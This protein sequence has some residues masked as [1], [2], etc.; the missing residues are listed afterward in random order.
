MSQGQRGMQ[1]YGSSMGYQP[2]GMNRGGFQP[3]NQNPTFQNAM[4]YAGQRMGQMPGFSQGQPGQYGMAGSS[5]NFRPPDGRGFTEPPPWNQN[6]GG[7]MVPSGGGSDFRYT[8]NDADLAGLQ[9]GSSSQV[10]SAWQ[11]S[12]SSSGGSMD[13]GRVG[14]NMAPGGYQNSWGGTGGM[15]GPMEKPMGIPPGTGG[16]SPIPQ[17]PQVQQMPQAPMNIQQQPGYANVAGF[18]PAR[19]RGLFGR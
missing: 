7:P 8:P 6:Q 2:Q 19:F 12:P 9:Q 4:G 1:N 11:P 5:V 18:N 15:Q 10:N 16:Y 13:G 17:M 3:T 14:G